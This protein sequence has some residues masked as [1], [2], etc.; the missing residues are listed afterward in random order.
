MSL[1]SFYLSGRDLQRLIGVH[2]DLVRTVERA[3]TLAPAPF[4][5]LEG[6]RALARHRQYFRA[7]KTR[8]MRSRHLTGHAV[9]LAP[10][11]D[12]DGDGDREVS[13]DWADFRPLA[14][15]VKLAAEQVGVPVEWGGDW[16]GFPDG[17]HWQLPWEVYP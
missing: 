14:R 15:A 5:V 9:D 1:A 6:L 10:L 11:I 16:K 3:A 4:M 17:P 2:P 8:T 13:W 7:G 12:T